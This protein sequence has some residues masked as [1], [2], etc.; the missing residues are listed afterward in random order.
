[1]KTEVGAGESHV[2]PAGGRYNW[3]ALVHPPQSDVTRALILHQRAER[4]KGV[5]AAPPIIPSQR[6]HEISETAIDA[7]PDV[8]SMREARRALRSARQTKK[9]M[10]ASRKQSKRY[11]QRGK[12][13]YGKGYYIPRR[14]IWLWLSIYVGTAL[15]TGAALGYVFFKLLSGAAGN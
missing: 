5:V 1:M 13:Q 4:A 15:M 2:T 11:M 14:Q 9:D 10:R 8:P 7:L 6:A 3:G 12:R